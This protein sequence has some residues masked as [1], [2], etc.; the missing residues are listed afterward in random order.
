MLCAVLFAISGAALADQVAR[1]LGASRSAEALRESVQAE[2]PLA[3]A[4]IA[5][6]DERTYTLLGLSHPEPATEFI[7]KKIQAK[8]EVANVALDEAGATFAVLDTFASRPEIQVRIKDISSALNGARESADALLGKSKFARKREPDAVMQTLRDQFTTTRELSMSLDV[9]DSVLPTGVAHQAKIRQTTWSMYQAMRGDVAILARAVAA[10]YSLPENETANSS[11]YAAQTDEAVAELA[12]AVESPD[13]SA[14][15]RAAFAHFKDAYGSVFQPLRASTLEGAA[16]GTYPFSLAEFDDRMSAVLDAA[17]GIL[18][19][20][21]ASDAATAAA[22]GAAARTQLTLALVMAAVVTLA[23]GG[24]AW[25]MTWHVAGR[26]SKITRLMMRLAEGD[27]SVDATRF[28][29]ADEIGE[30]ADAVEVFRQNALTMKKLQDEQVA[31]KASADAERRAMLD[32]LAS[33]FEQTVMTA[34]ATVTD[35]SVEVHRSSEMLDSTAADAISRSDD[36]TRTSA[37]SQA[38]VQA[39]CAAVEELATSAQTIEQSVGRVTSVAEVA[40]QRADETQAI[41][42][43]LETAGSQ[44][45]QIVGLITDIAEQTNLLALNAT[46][47]AARAGEAGRGFAV[48]AQEVKSLADQTSRATGEIERQISQIQSTTGSAVGAIGSISQTVGELNLIAGTIIQTVKSQSGAIH[49]INFTIGEVARSAGEVSDT[50]AVVSAGASDTGIAARSCLDTSGR[51]GEAA[52]R[53]RDEVT[54]F[55]G[56]IRAV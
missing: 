49:E 36:M 44:I 9:A 55:V 21:S 34:V 6:A 53:L 39:V 27:T 1:A 11:L 23:I 35:A 15:V 30:M 45:G 33:R 10:R 56:R 54:T 40:T 24:L 37:Q 48:V 3:N 52:N 50:I 31:S 2:A 28:R 43:A 19:A 42:K 12:R 32:G 17:A 51:L 16:V 46:I 14:D 20:V 5:L 8:R 18:Q 4:A 26:V 29:S 13:T 38:S 47:E 25:F 22:F 41:V 7:R